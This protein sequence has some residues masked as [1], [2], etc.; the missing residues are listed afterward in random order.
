MLT[1]AMGGP[2]SDSI[3]MY[4]CLCH[5]GVYSCKWTHVNMQPLPVVCVRDCVCV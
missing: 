4:K 2:L 1:E 5:W 3:C